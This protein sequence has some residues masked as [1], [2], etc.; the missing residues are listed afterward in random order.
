MFHLFK[1]KNS[2]PLLRQEAA[3]VVQQACS[4]AQRAAEH[5]GALG[6]LFAEEVKEYTTHQLQRVVMLVVACVLLLGA[7]FVFC[8]A[9]SVLLSIWMHPSLALAMV[10]FINLVAALLLLLMVRRMGGKKLAPLTAQE[11]R[12]DWECLKLL[13]KGSS[14]H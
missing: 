6:S 8:A 13:C 5:S 12:N 1:S 10:C 11:L 9:L 4:V 7:Y 3:A 2:V 14:K